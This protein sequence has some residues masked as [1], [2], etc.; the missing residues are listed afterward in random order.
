MQGVVLSSLR[1]C[2]TGQ[3]RGLVARMLSLLNKLVFSLER[4][5][6]PSLAPRRNGLQVF[7]LELL[8]TIPEIEDDFSIFLMQASNHEHDLE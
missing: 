5:I 7:R 2:G 1:A 6:V 3:D 4:V 8:L